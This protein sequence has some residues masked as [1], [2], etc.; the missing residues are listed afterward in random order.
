ML[1]GEPP[2]P[3]KN[4]RLT[5]LRAAPAVLLLL[6]SGALWWHPLANTFRLALSG[7]EYTYLLL[8]IP[9]STGLIFLER[10]R[11]PSDL[12]P[13]YGTCVPFLGLALILYEVARWKA[14]ALP[15][16]VP[17]FLSMVALAI[18][19]IASAL[20]WAGIKGFRLLL[21]PV[22]F[23]FLVA[24]L[25]QFVVD[26]L[27]HPLQLCSAYAARI[28]FLAAGVPVTQDGITLSIPALDIVVARECSSIRS[29]SMLF[30]VSMVLAHLFLRS[31]WRKALFIAATVPLAA[32]KNGFRIFVITEIATRVDPT[33]FGGQFHRHGGIVFLAL[34]LGLMFGLLKLLRKTEP[35]SRPGFA[36]A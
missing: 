19:W 24:P 34:S 12:A 32:L 3:W 18:W 5:K 14:A 29:S 16:G 6:A 8:I 23:L 33:F 25:P 2:L 20:C 27:T 22:L 13:A 4:V 30:L 17:I 1:Q 36:S 26:E 31:W 7:D 28:M 10:R 21:F 35:P 15:E 9:I 11:F